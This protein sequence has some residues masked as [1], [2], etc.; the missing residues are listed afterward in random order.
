MRVLIAPDK[1]KGS[2][3]AAEVATAIAQGLD[4]AGVAYTVLPLAD[5]GDGSVAAAL[6]A[7]FTAHPVVVTGADRRPVHTELAFRGATAVVEVA[8]T[9]GLTTLPQGVLAPM[10]SSS[11]GFGQAI[12]A[13]LEHGARRIVLALGGSASTDAGA[14]MLAALGVSFLDRTGREVDPA[15]ETLAR[16][17]TVDARGLVDLSG[18]E[19]ILAADVTNPLLGAEGASAVFA[20]QKGASPAQLRQLEAGL[21]HFAGVLGPRIEDTSDE[22]ARDGLA[23]EPGAG[24]AGGIGFACRWLGARPVPGADYF[25]DLLGFDD[26]VASCDAVITGE[27]RLDTQTLG[28]KLPAVV[29]ARSAPRPVYAVVGQSQLSNTEQRRLGIQEVHALTELSDT[30]SSHDPALSRRLAAVASEA[31]AHSARARNSSSLIPGRCEL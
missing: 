25:L 10:T 21:D 9:C 16:I 5:G 3:T 19:L 29:A 22:H 23:D 24:A 26:A 12:A 28:G 27:G 11:F 18:V 8:N 30:D 31:I 2:L 4:A 1:F 20:P 14:G 6:A 7:G 17:A 15:G 13:A